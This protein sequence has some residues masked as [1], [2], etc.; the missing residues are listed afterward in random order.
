MK[1][2]EIK[3]LPFLDTIGRSFKYVLKNKALIRGIL[4]LAAAL[5]VLQAL[6]GL[7]FLCSLSGNTCV[8][9]W[10]WPV[11]ALTI[12]LSVAGIIINYCR[13]II[14]K[15]PVDFVSIQFWKR[16]GFYV[17][18]FLVLSV[19]ILVPVL[20]CL[21]LAAFVFD[22]STSISLLTLISV[23]VWFAA[24][25]VFAPL[26]LVFPAIAVEDYEMIK[27]SKLFALAKGNCNAIFWA[28]LI[29]MLPCWILAKMWSSI[30]G[31]IGSD[32]YIIGLVFVAGGLFISLV[33]AC[34]KG[35]YFAHIY[36]FFKFYDKK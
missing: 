19:L 21:T 9:D 34:F 29:I 17:V 30:Y 27:W 20:L 26:L 7:P 24:A 6:I 4:P 35:A 16:M 12:A 10:R 14:N 2:P 31:I 15:A 5:I 33:D 32:N 3:K 36:Q 23:L 13:T 25:I 1:N 28:H 11:T 18:A 8:S 22:P